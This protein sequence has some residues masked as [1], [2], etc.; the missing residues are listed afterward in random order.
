MHSPPASRPTA[1]AAPC[2]STIPRSPPLELLGA[3]VEGTGV[4]GELE[5]NRPHSRGSRER[6]LVEARAERLVV[7]DDTRRIANDESGAAHAGHGGMVDRRTG[8]AIGP[9]IVSSSGDAGDTA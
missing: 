9:G 8:P 5:L 7:Y 1:S 6:R 3:D 4:I 2:R